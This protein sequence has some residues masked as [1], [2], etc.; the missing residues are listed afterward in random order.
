MLGT[1]PKSLSGHELLPPSS[2]LSLTDV[3]QQG[4]DWIV[5]ADGPAQAACPTCGRVSHVAP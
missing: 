2:L 3:Q 4:A 1:M 5:R